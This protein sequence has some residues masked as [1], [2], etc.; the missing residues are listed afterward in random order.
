MKYQEDGQLKDIYVKASDTLPIGA[1][2]EI[3][4]DMEVPDGYELVEEYENVYSSEE[5]VIGIWFGKPLYRRMFYYG[6]LPSNDTKVVDHNILNV[7]HIHINL[8]KS[9]WN[10]KDENIETSSSFTFIFP[11]YIFNMSVRRNAVVIET[12]N[13]DASNF[14]ALLCLEYTKT[15]DE[16]IS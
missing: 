1:T 10:S 6:L 8:G 11:N 13:T 9:F 12:N 2:V 14:H 15:T 5:E 3:P 7:E 16:V 4:D